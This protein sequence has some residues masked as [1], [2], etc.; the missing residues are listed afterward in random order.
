MLS[1]I[2]ELV[3]PN[4]IMDNSIIWSYIAA[5]NGFAIWNLRSAEVTAD[6]VVLAALWAKEEAFIALL[7]A[8]ISNGNNVDTA[9]I[10][11][12]IQNGT[13]R[14]FKKLT[15]YI[16]IKG[17]ITYS[18]IYHDRDDLMG[19]VQGRSNLPEDALDY[20]MA[21]NSAKVLR[22][23]MSI[24]LTVNDSVIETGLQYGSVDCLIE[25]YLPQ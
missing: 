19:V 20:A 10:S 15:K 13:V 11:A 2:F 14:M 1:K 16:S 6:K 24:G 4:G 22:W 25:M 23:L 5:D 18:V 9:I 8:Y 21:C 7:E 3:S 17:I 12:C